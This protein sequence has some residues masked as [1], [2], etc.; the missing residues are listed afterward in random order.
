LSKKKKKKK[1]K[2]LEWWYDTSATIHVCN[3]KSQ[4]KNYEDAMVGQQLLMGNHDTTKV[5]GKGT[6]EL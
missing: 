6:V 2:S 5:E 3:N 1:K 4:F